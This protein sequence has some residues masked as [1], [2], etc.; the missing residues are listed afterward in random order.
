MLM[1]Y[2]GGG[3]R[4]LIDRNNRLYALWAADYFVIVFIDKDKKTS[5]FPV[6]H[7]VCYKLAI[8]PLY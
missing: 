1:A 2:G 6:E 5:M 7:A 3:S 8:S 4:C